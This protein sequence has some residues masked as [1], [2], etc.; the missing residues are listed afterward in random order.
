LFIHAS[1]LSFEPE[2]TDVTIFTQGKGNFMRAIVL[3]GPN[4]HEG[5]YRATVTTDS[6]MVTKKEAL[7][8]YKM[9]WV[10]DE[11]MNG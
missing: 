11:K 5:S 3:D 2:G 1:S 6:H 4:S 9:P 8:L 7:T 10:L